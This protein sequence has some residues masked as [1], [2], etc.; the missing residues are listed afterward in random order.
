MAYESHMDLFDEAIGFVKFSRA[1]LEILRR[2]APVLTPLLP[3]M[4]EEF[5][6]LLLKHPK[7]MKVF[8]GPEQIDRLKRTLALWAEDLLTEERDEKYVAKR[9]RIGSVHVDL[10]IQ[11]IHIMGAMGV[12]RQFLIRNMYELAPPELR[13]SARQA[14][15]RATDLDLIL[16]TESYQTASHL[17][18]IRESHTRFRRLLV[19]API[20]VFTFNEKGEIEDWNPAAER[21]F[22]I[23]QEKMES[24]DFVKKLIPPDDRTFTREVITQ[25]MSGNT[26][27][28]LEK[29][30]ETG[31]NV[32]VLSTVV[33]A[34]LR[35][36]F[37]VEAGVA[38]CLDV[39]EIA[40]LREKITDQEKMSALGTLA[41]GLAHEVGNP[42]SSI[43]A[44]VQLIQKKGAD[45][46]LGEKMQT[47]SGALD[48]IDS[49]VRRVLDFARGG[50]EKST[51]QDLKKEIDQVLALARLDRRLK[52]LDIQ[53]DIEKDLP[54]VKAP[55][56]GL[57]QVLLNL[58]LNA[59]E[60][61]WEET[62][63]GW[64]KIT[65]KMSG[66][67]VVISVGDSGP[68]F[69]KESLRRAQEPFFTTKKTGT[70][71]GLAVS[72]GIIERLGGTLT[73]GNHPEGGGEVRLTLPVDS[74]PHHS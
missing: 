27:G 4:A 42:L 62:G 48:R 33:F 7:A 63:E 29:R 73:L 11:T 67:H 3:D 31:K 16:M 53:I 34:P 54:M 39:G 69:T 45:D 25:V 22:G 74:D 49:I 9:I 41:A 36:E 19:Q 8:T 21:L 24:R 70:G 35:N 51:T 18:D 71:L 38:F 52:R 1:D 66:G 46:T 43:S 15:S 68:G 60:A 2:I 6:Q 13:E 72:Y 58:L 65:G 57:S 55:K 30:F 10:G 40:E 12:V 26:V 64:I 50:I 56:A 28:P 14:I 20:G 47:I 17:R 32:S 37:G 61:V 23:T 59:G 44:I 5:Y